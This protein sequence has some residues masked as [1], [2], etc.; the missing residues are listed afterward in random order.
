MTNSDFI[1]IYDNLLSEEECKI[2]IDEFE[3]GLT[4]SSHTPVRSENFH[5]GELTRKDL[6]LFANDGLFK[7]HDIVNPALQKCIDFYAQEFFIL[8]QIKAR[9]LQIKVQKT[10]PRGGYH[11]WHCEADSLINSS[12]CLVWMIYLNDMPEGEAETEFL[13]QGVRVKPTRGTCVMW[14]ASWTHTHRGNPVY[15]QDKYIVTGWYTH[16]G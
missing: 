9:S 7:T 4:T 11:G 2:I 6:C 3:H 14:P 13:W 15:S 5:G 8:K 16:N 1:G 12:R 10:S